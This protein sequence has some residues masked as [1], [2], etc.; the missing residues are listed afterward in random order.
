[1]SHK[2]FYKNTND[3]FDNTSDIHRLTTNTAK[4]IRNVKEINNIDTSKVTRVKVID[5]QSEPIVGRAYG[6]TDCKKVE[7]Q[8]QDDNRTLK[9][10]ISK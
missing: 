2:N 5:H 1:M 7:I 4:K 8:L 6:K 10:F 9:I 3:I